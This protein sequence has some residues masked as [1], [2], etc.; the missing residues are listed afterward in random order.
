MGTYMD[1]FN[2][3]RDAWNFTYTGK[4]LVDVC[5]AKWQE[6][7]RR[8]KKARQDASS[9][10]SNME[11]TRNDQRVVEAETEISRCGSAREQLEIFIMEFSRNPTREYTLGIGDVS[12]FD[13]H[14][15]VSKELV[16]AES[17]GTGE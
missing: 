10:M 15:A 17:T 2:S 4:D 7:Y 8:E 5:K 12:Y 1:R 14:T 3:K 6:M 9:L 11:I 16:T 13:L